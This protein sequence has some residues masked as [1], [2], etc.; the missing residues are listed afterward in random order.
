MNDVAKLQK[1]EP[2]WDAWMGLELAESEN[3]KRER[4]IAQAG[5]G[6]GIFTSFEIAGRKKGEGCCPFTQEPHV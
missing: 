1:L 2:E 3:G 4:G 6:N 5:N